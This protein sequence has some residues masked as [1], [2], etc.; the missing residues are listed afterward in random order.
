MGAAQYSAQGKIGKFNQSVANRNAL[1]LEGQ[2]DQIEAKAE[3]DIAQFQK[4]FKKMEGTTKVALAKSGVVM[5]SGSAYNI[6][7]SNAYE[8][9][10][11]EQLI[12]YNSEVAVANKMEEANFARI[13]GQ[14]AKN[15]AKLAQI[16][17]VAQTGSNIYSMMGG[18]K[19]V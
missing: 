2:A 14:M 15:E 7:L 18:G 12:K 1:I 11:Q 19:K 13:S 10:L 8:A 16:T 9:K 4:D 3:F 6:Q 5:D 17:T